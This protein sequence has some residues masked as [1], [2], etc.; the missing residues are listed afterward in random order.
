MCVTLS[1]AH[2]TI[3]GVHGMAWLCG[4]H[5]VVYRTCVNHGP[6]GGA[7][8]A[9]LQTSAILQPADILNAAAAAAPAALLVPPCL[10]LCDLL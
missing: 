4:L 10:L 5:A 8:S 2:G 9:A 6:G 7:G 1:E 3:G